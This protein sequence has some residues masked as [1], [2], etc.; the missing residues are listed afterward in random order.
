MTQVANNH[1]VSIEYKVEDKN[2]GELLDASRDAPFVFVL[3][4]GHVISGLEDA[5][6]GKEVGSK[7]VVEIKPEDAYG[8]Y[9]SSLLQEVPVEQF[10]GIELTK[11]MT[12]FGQSEGG[13]T[14]QVIVSEIGKDHII[15]DQNHPLAGKT[16]LFDVNILDA[17]EISE[18]ELYSL[19]HGE[20]CGSGC[21]CGSHAKEEEEEDNQGCGCG[22]G[23]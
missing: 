1:R 16:L 12:L 9:D 3:G 7:F 4:Q 19:Q 22:C 14:I 10:S 13:S 21:G 23:H 5:L 15:I 20:G 8:F 18:E 6:L 11:G 17:K 2:T